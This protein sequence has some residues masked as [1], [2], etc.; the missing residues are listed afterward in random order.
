MQES[1]P[2]LWVLAKKATEYKLY[3]SPNV[4][5]EQG[6][7]RYNTSLWI[8]PDGQ[9]ADRAKLVHI[10]QAMQNQVFIAMCNRVGRG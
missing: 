5:L 6:G 3:L 7:K 4:Y 9:I 2:E 8:T 10:A 1:A